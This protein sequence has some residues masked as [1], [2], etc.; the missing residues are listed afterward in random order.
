MKSRNCIFAIAMISCIIF[1]YNCKA[2]NNYIKDIALIKD[3]LSGTTE[4]IHTYLDDLGYS[5]DILN[6]QYVTHEILN[7]YRLTIYLPAIINMHV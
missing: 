5:S 4:L 6:S 3:D 1:T 7:Q 2:E